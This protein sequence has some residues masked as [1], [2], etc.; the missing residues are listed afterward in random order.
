MILDSLDNRARY[1]SLHPGFAAA[2]QLLQRA[3][4]RELEPGRHAVDDPRLALIIGKYTGLGREG[5]KLEA[6]RRHIDIQLVTA[7]RDEIGWRP[8]AECRQEKTSYSEEH[9][10]IVFDDA[11][12]CWCRVPAA[13]FAIFF[14]DDAHAPLGGVGML[15]K[16]VV[17]VALNW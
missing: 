6:H 10:E 4:L 13:N 8:L 15:Q 9:D 12:E 16:A 5:A 14:P 11:I 17:K 2:F 3:D 1:L 7:G